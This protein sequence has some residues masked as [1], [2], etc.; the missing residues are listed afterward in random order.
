MLKNWAM[1]GLGTGPRGAVQVDDARQLALL[2]GGWLNEADER[3][4]DDE[5]SVLRQLLPDRR[6]GN[7]FAVVDHGDD[8][9][10]SRQ[11]V[12]TVAGCG[13]TQTAEDAEQ[14]QAANTGS[15][16]HPKP[17]CKEGMQSCR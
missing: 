14:H 3:P 15:G 5:L 8:L 12:R 6:R 17:P 11:G 13:G 2:L 1:M 7:E 9:P 4:V 16:N 10:R